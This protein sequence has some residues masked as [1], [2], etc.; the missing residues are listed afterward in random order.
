MKINKMRLTLQPI[1]DDDLGF[2]CDLYKTTRE[3]EMSQVSW[4]AE[5]IDAFLSQQFNLQHSYYTA[6]FPNAKF[7]IIELDGKRIGRLYTDTGAK[8]IR[9]I[10]VALLPKYRN[11]GIGTHYMKG[12]L[13]EAEANN[14]K[15]TLHVEYFNPA[16]NL[17]LRLGFQQI[18][19]YGSN[20]FMEWKPAS[21]SQET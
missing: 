7:D 2:L 16:L 20:A 9:V 5:E 6:H 11:Q 4:S 19:E 12:I 14:M 1:T 13:A 10:D 15:V 3:V 21:F 18:E 8:D 17:Y